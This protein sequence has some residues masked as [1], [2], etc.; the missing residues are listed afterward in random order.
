MS[1]PVPVS[2][3]SIEAAIRSELATHGLRLLALVWTRN[4]VSL[5]SAAQGRRGVRLR[6]SRRLAHLGGAVV[7]PIVAFVR[8]GPGARARLR[9]LFDALPAGEGPKRRVAA[10]RPAGDVVDLRNFLAGP[11]SLLAMD[12]ATVRITWGPRRPV[13]AGQRTFRLG[14]YDPLTDTV[15][16]HRVLDDSRVPTWYLEYVIHHELVHRFLNQTQ[17]VQ[18][19]RA[20]GA[21]FRQL[22]A[23]HEGTSK[24]KEWER[25]NLPRLPRQRRSSKTP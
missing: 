15:R 25:D 20:H 23:K 17:G 14:S 1:I 22:E 5:V 6:V 9:S 21:S 19:A 8:G 16:L 7:E 3:P 11:C 10:L 4:R 24:A 13:R 2:L 18:A 12:P